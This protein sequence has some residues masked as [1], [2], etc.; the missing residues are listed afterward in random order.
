V[1]QERLQNHRALEPLTLGALCTARMMT[2]RMPGEAPRLLV[3]CYRMPVGDLPADNYSQ[4]GLV[5]DIDLETGRLGN[6]LRQDEQ[7]IVVPVDRHPSTAAPIQGH[8]LPWWPEA[9]RLVVEAHAAAGRMVFVGWDVA[10]LAGGP[11]LVEA[12]LVPGSKLIQM[13]SGVPLGETP[14][15]ACVNAHLRATFGS[16]RRLR[17]PRAAVA[18]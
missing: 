4:G 5:A 11:V 10:F 7:R 8:Q 13:P 14:W 18:S 9:V 2:Y 17:P 3:A 15:V 12:N 6:A 16:P 1:L